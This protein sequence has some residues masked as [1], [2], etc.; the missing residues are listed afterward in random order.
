MKSHIWRFAGEEYEG[1]KKYIEESLTEH[2]ND[3]IGDRVESLLGGVVIYQ[4]TAGPGGTAVENAYAL[5]VTVTVK[6][7][8]DERFDPKAEEEVT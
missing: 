4:V 7:R 8:R 2:A 1:T 6:L 5:E 3:Q